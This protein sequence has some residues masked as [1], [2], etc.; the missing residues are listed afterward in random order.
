MSA[1]TDL[2]CPTVDV[3]P[4]GLLAYVRTEEGQKRFRYGAVSAIAILCSM[5]SLALF[6]GLLKW[7]K[8]SAQCASVIVSTV[9]SYEL[10]RRWV[11]LRDG[12]SD[13]K[14]EV[15][16]FWVV[17]VVQFV[18]ALVIVTWTQ[19]RVEQATTSHLLRTIGIQGI[20]LAVYGVMWVGKYILLNRVLFADKTPEEKAL[21]ELMS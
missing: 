9:P 11:W 16:P 15:L 14:T 13:L 2:G 18:I 12:K 8:I 5:L 10:N 21:S 17:S 1:A 7:S 19:T 4:R 6:Y 3:S 20:S